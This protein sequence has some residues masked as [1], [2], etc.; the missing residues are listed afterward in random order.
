MK[1]IS[2][3]LNRLSQGPVAKPKKRYKLKREKRSK[4]KELV[5]LQ[6]KCLQRES[7]VHKK[8]SS[9]GSAV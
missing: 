6:H 7:N 9:N 8:A 2:D 1:A 4:E 3:Q 5:R